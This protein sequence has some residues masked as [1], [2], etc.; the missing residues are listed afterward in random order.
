MSDL[1]D[2]VSQGSDKTISAR[3]RALA[4]AVTSL[5]VGIA[6]GVTVAR[7]TAA[8]AYPGDGGV[9]YV[10]R[11]NALALVHA[12]GLSD[13]EIEVQFPLRGDGTLLPIVA[14][15]V[16]VLAGKATGFQ[17]YRPVDGQLALARVVGVPQGD[18]VEA[19][20]GNRRI[21]VRVERCGTP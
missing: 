4:L 1:Q 6:V 10:C 15:G 9:V 12:S 21:S 20:V 14:E 13:R 18:S 8:E 17:Y 7:S 5:V 2:T 16:Q 19:L 11:G 3:W